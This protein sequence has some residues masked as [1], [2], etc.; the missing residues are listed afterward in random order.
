MSERSV[1]GRERT[2]R[3][4]EQNDGGFERSDV[5]RA[6]QGHECGRASFDGDEER[7]REMGCG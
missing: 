7:E 2:E 1:G 3:T 5:V 4:T 6:E